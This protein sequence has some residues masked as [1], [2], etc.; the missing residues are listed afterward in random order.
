MRVTPKP[1]RASRRQKK[2]SRL[3]TLIILMTTT[4]MVATGGFG[5]FPENSL[6]QTFQKV[7]GQNIPADFLEPFNSYMD[8]ISAPTIEPKPAPEAQAVYPLNILNTLIEA[9]TKV[10]P[11]P[12]PLPSVPAST[13]HFTPSSAQAKPSPT[14]TITSTPTQTATFPQSPPSAATCHITISKAF[15]YQGPNKGYPLE[16]NKS[17]NSENEFKVIARD[18]TGTWLFGE[19]QD[20]TQGWMPIEWL[21]RSCYSN[22]PIP[23]AS[24]IPLVPTERPPTRKPPER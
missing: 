8:A 18:R 5:T 12:P 19:L 13:P 2:K 16:N 15:V 1:P 22:T 11:S 7:I 3:Q 17:Y 10:N 23:T 6:T 24:F 20:S 9:F 21:S 14:N 4:A